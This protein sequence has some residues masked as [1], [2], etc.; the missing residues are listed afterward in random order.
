MAGAAGIVATASAVD[1]KP[2]DRRYPGRA[3]R[4][5]PGGAVGTSKIQPDQ[6]ANL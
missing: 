2:S 3:Y 4:R 5:V 1:T 6:G